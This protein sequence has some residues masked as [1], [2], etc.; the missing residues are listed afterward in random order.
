[1]PTTSDLRWP[2]QA[3]MELADGKGGYHDE[4]QV[5]RFEP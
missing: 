3:L 2:A 5:H 4:I 1:M